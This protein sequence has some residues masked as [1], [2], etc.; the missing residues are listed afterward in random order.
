MGRPAR[1]LDRRPVVNGASG[2]RR[3]RRPSDGEDDAGPNGAAAAV[4]GMVLIRLR[5]YVAAIP[6]HDARR[7]AL[8]HEAPVPLTIVLRMLRGESGELQPSPTTGSSTA[9]ESDAADQARPTG[10]VLGRPC[11]G[12]VIRDEIHRV[13]DP[14]R[15]VPI[16]KIGH[17]MVTDAHS[18]EMVAPS[19]SAVDGT[20]RGVVRTLADVWKQPAKRRAVRTSL[21]R[22]ARYAHRRSRRRR[23]NPSLV[24]G[25]EPPPSVGGGLT[26]RRARGAC[27]SRGPLH[28]SARSRSAGGRSLRGRCRHRSD[29]PG[30]AVVAPRRRSWTARALKRAM[31]IVGSAVA[32]VVLAP[33]LLVLAIAS[34]VRDGRASDLRAATCRPVGFTLPDLQVPHDVSPARTR[35]CRAGSS[36]DEAL[37][38]EWAALRK[39]RDD[40]RVT[41]LDASSGDT[42]S[43]SFRSS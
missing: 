28:R 25:H 12:G 39:L 13:V 34:G 6:R 43:M 32:L 4:D 8:E 2:E 29:V 14:Q 38:R 18:V 35:S 33:L 40:P 31:D 37:A 24:S 5:T 36:D 10:R 21:Q 9:R 41:R 15:P 11:E 42:A 3:A 1:Q 22:R 26:R 17:S 19:R 27:S 16:T 7:L 20:N 23:D 30:R